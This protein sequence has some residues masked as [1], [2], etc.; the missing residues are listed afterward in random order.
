MQTRREGGRRGT[1]ALP[2]GGAER[3]WAMKTHG[4]ELCWGQRGVRAD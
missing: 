3:S 4:M 1:G 2:V